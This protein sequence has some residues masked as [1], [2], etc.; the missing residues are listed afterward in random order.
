MIGKL[1]G[2]TQIGTTQRYAHLIESP[3]RGRQRGGRDAAAA[4][5][6]SRQPEGSIARRGERSFCDGGL[7]RSGETTPPSRCSPGQERHIADVRTLGLRPL[8]ACALLLC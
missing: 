6:T 3:L 5:Y 1:L 7:L 4:A 8:R 2:H